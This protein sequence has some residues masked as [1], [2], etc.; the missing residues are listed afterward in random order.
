MSHAFSLDDCVLTI[1]GIELRGFENAQDA[2]V[3]TPV[4]DDGDITY[5]INGDGVFVSSC[6]K[7]ATIAIKGLQHSEMNRILNDLRSRQINNMRTASG[8][9]ISFK[10]LRNGDEF[11]LT[12]CWFTTPPTHGRGTAHNGNTWTLKAVKA[13]IKLTEGYI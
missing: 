1:N 3:I 9:I 11:T 7:G 5:G 4:G 12:G 6:N 10:D 13:E 8:N 2:V